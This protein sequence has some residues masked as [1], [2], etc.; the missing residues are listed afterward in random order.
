MRLNFKSF[1]IASL[2]GP[3]FPFY[4]LKSSRVVQSHVN[5]KVPHCF[6][7]YSSTSPDFNPKNE[8]KRPRLVSS[9]GQSVRLDRLLANRGLGSRKEVAS[10]LKKGR[11]KINGQIVQGAS[12]KVN[13]NV[14]ITFDGSIVDPIPLLVA[15][16]KPKGIISTM[17][18][19]WGRKHLKDSVPE[20]YLKHMH[21]VGRLDA[22]SSGLL[23]LSSDGTLT[24][25]LLQPKFKVER[26][27]KCLVEPKD[28]MPPP[29]HSL[30]DK[31]FEGVATADGI[32]PGEITGIEGCKVKV[33]VKEGKYRMVRRML[34]NAGYPVLELHRFRY[35]DIVMGSELGEGE[36]KVIEGRALRWAQWLRKTP[37]KILLAEKS[38]SV[39]PQEDI[40]QNHVS[41]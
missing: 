26:E 35:G 19:D 7:L 6:R 22:D 12:T 9:I 21:P 10:Y 3:M 4:L 28:G 32:F 40:R 24:H 16:H 15:Y 37:E 18:D 2:C 41:A 20:I 11:I 31:V 33:I 23:L 17:S 36:C 29:G 30:I 13:D 25:K 27:Y 34:A 1:K 5:S 8:N 39:L 38:A 14:K